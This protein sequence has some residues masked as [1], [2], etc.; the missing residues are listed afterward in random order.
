MLKSCFFHS[1][2]RRG[3]FVGG[4][5]QNDDSVYGDSESLKQQFRNQHPF[6]DFEDVVPDKGERGVSAASRG[7]L[8]LSPSPS[9]RLVFPV[10][11]RKPLVVGMVESVFSSVPESKRYNVA[12]GPL[13][14]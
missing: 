5:S 11:N 13:W 10:E 8:D 2:N 3:L 7:P 1:G 14:I 12:C 9:T 4:R 6:Y